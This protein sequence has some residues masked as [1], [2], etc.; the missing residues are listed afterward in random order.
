MAIIGWISPLTGYVSITGS[1]SDGAPGS[2][3]GIQWY[4][5]RDS[6]GLASG[7]INNGGSQVF[8][9]GTGGAGL[10]SVAV[11]TVDKIYRIVHPKANISV[12]RLRL[13]S[14]SV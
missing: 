8:S 4:I 14:R 3:D 12:I 2:G 7:N 9:S 1:L 10:N 13:I 5:D 6:V 11:T